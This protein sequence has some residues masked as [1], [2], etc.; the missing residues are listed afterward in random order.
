MRVGLALLLLGRSIAE[1]TPRVG[2]DGMSAEQMGDIEELHQFW[3]K[4]RG[5]ADS[6]ICHTF[7]ARREGKAGGW[8]MPNRPPHPHD[9]QEMHQAFCE[10]EANAA[11]HPCKRWQKHQ[12]FKSRERASRR[13]SE[14]A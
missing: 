12:K 1:D 14:E 4:D 10:I 3:C 7:Y 8:R 9:L 13:N 11:K 5:H 2:R 6:M